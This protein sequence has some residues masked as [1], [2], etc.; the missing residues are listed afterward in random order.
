MLITVF[1]AS[2]RETS[3]PIRDNYTNNYNRHAAPASQPARQASRQAG[4]PLLLTGKLPSTAQNLGLL[5]GTLERSS[6]L[7]PKLIFSSALS[8]FLYFR[9]AEEGTATLCSSFEGMRAAARESSVLVV[10]S[11]L[12]PKWRSRSASACPS[13]SRGSWRPAARTRPRI[14]CARVCRS[15]CPRCLQVSFSSFEVDLGLDRR[16]GGLASL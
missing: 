2:V 8:F 4:K 15:R 13:A 12:R 9:R 5:V 3:R 14:G 1:S 16:K 10:F 7:A 6:R 11:V